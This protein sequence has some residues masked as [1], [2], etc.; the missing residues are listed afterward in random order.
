MRR[1]HAGSPRR[2]GH[3]PACPLPDR[4]EG[5]GP[6]DAA[7]VDAA[8][9]DRAAPDVPGRVAAAER[10]AAHR[11]GRAQP[12]PGLLR[13][14]VG[15]P[16]GRDLPRRPGRGRGDRARPR[17]Q[18]RR[19]QRQPRAHAP[20]RPLRRG[21][22]PAGRRRRGRRRRAPGQHQDPRRGRHLRRLQAPRRRLLRLHLRLRRPRDA[23]AL[24]AVPRPHQALAGLVG[25][26]LLRTRH[27]ERAAV[28]TCRLPRRASPLACALLFCF[29]SL[30]RPRRC[31]VTV[32][33]D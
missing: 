15:G 2:A 6:H 5:P 28:R 20:G 1:R 7:G 18:P 32:R 8:G 13:L 14:R 24:P 22:R 16:H 23:G 33:Y 31:L 26:W 4:A 19:R 30:S 17:A 3:N 27:V 12:E 21:P 29:A 11:G 10:D 9:R 25:C